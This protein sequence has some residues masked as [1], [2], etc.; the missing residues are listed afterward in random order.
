MI[1]PFCEKDIK[2]SEQLKIGQTVSCPYCAEK[3]IVTQLN[4]VVLEWPDGDDWEDD[5]VAWKNKPMK[6]SS[7]RVYDPR[8]AGWYE[9][10]DWGVG[11][12]DVKIR[13][14]RLRKKSVNSQRDAR[15]RRYRKDES[16]QDF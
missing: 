7:K 5:E 10:A 4:P 16:F 8:D 15:R 6:I 11:G 3:L 1:C 13:E 12:A 2:L 14:K 9:D